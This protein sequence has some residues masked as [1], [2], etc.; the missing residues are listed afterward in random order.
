[1]TY[2]KLVAAA[3]IVA[4]FCPA[5]PAAPRWAIVIHG[6]AGVIE[7]KDITPEQESAYRASLKRAI[8]AGIDVLKN[9]GTSLD[10]V[11]AAIKL[12]SRRSGTTS[13]VGWCLNQN[14][15]HAA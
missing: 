13:A 1:M 15:R 7:R 11:E 6:G 12:M 5:V 8:D 10:A 3:L 2:G 9:R 14:A 4:L